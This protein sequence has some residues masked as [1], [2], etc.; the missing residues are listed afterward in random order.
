MSSF[1]FDTGLQAWDD[2]IDGAAQVVR[3]HI[4]AD[5]DEFASKM[6]QIS[7][8]S[9][10]QLVFHV[11]PYGKVEGIEVWTVGRPLLLGEEIGTI[12]PQLELNSRSCD[13]EVIVVLTP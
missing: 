7:D 9:V 4:V 13:I 1:S 10:L 2:G 11:T 3:V 5:L 8:F 6:I 12:L